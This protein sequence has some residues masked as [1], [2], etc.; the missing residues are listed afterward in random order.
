MA[1]NGKKD[2]LWFKDAIF[3][4]LSVRSFYDSNSDGIGDFPG[5]IQKLDYLED[6]G[7][8]ALWLLPFYPSPL[9]DDG[10]DITEYCDIHPDY[11]TLK[12][13]KLFL[14]E[15]HQRGIRVVTEL[16]LNHTS[17]QHPWFEKSR[18]AREA[19]AI[20]IT[21]FG[22]K[23]LKNLRKHGSYFPMKSLP[24]GVGTTKP[25]RTIGIGFTGISRN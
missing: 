10:F 4:E 9:K 16:I 21:T 20:K 7:V 5:L 8:N 12:D 2:P 6:L 19:P 13:F 24:I 22:A 23:L 14:K 3:Y 25:R 15:A 1:A 17:D 18:R 11:G